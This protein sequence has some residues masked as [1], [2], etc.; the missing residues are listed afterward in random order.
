MDV[1]LLDLVLPDMSGSALYPLIREH[2]PLAK[3]IVCSGYGL[4]GPTQEL[5]DAGADGFIQKPYGL[6]DIHETIQKVISSGKDTGNMKNR[7][8]L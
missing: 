1:V 4:A 2:R 7:S 6:N 3:V 8:M 5:L